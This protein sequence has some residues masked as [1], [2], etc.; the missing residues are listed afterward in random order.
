M[1]P[2]LNQFENEFAKQRVCPGVPWSGE[3]R[4][5]ILV[6]GLVNKTRLSI[7]VSEP[8]QALP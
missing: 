4:R 7:R 6:K 5:I 2:F 1:R 8:T 3:L